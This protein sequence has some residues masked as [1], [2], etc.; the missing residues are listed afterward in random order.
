MTNVVD[1]FLKYVKVHTSSEYDTGTFPSTA[2]QFDLAKA[3]VEEMKVMGLQEVELDDKCY[4]YA[5][6]PAN[7][8]E[9]IPTIGLIAH[10]D[11]S[12]EAPGENVTPRIIK[13]Y[14]GGDILLNQELNM[15]LTP[16]EFPEMLKYIGQDIITTDGNT[17]LGADDK[18]GV[19]IILTAMEYLLGHPEIKHGRVRIGFTPDEEIGHGADYFDVKKFHADFAY[20]LDGGEMG[21]LEYECFNAAMAKVHVQGR[22]VHPGTAKNQMVNAI[23]L[24]F[25]FHSLLPAVE[26]PEYT[27]KYEGFYHLYD[28]KADVEEARLVYIIRD[29]DRTKF[30]ARK[31]IFLKAAEFVNQTVGAERVQVEMIEQYQNMKEVILPKFHVVETAEQAMKELGITPKIGPIRGG[32]DGARLSYQGLPTPNI[33][34]GGHNF[35]G[36]YEYLPIPSLEKSVQVVLKILDLY[37][38]NPKF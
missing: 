30:E 20:T 7:T 21:E 29:H 27:E 10:M 38:K 2:R 4:L 14:D 11:T 28:F 34:A 26:R 8:D 25:Q 33:F 16:R 36:R 18:A 3:L 37:A 32:T 12:P 5:T 17:L 13:K 19:A 15:V 35:H 31:R 22:S 24:A 1:R 9:K 23:E 6:L